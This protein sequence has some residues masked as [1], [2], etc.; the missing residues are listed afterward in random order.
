[1]RCG[2]V[3]FL[4]RKAAKEEMKVINHHHKT[5]KTIKDVYYCDDCSAWHLTSMNK[6]KSRDFRRNQ[7]KRA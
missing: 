4:S 7:N 1:M 6:K 5:D 3:P 2:K